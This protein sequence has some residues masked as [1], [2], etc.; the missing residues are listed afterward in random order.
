MPP[1]RK[2]TPEDALS[3]KSVSDAQ[4]SPDGSQVA[5]V[6]GDSF[7]VDTR[8]SRSNIWI[9]DNEVGAT[10]RQ[11]TFEPR[12]DT[13]P[14]WSPDGQS[15]AFLSDR[16]K[17]GQRQVYLL[18]AHGGEGERLTG[19]EG[20]VPS[21]RSLS[22]IAWSPDGRQIAFLMTDPE[23]EEEK[24]R[25]KDKDDAVEF[26]KHG[27]FT[28]INVLDVESR[29]IVYT[30]PA[31]LQVW[32]FCWAP[33]GKEFAVVAS[34]L[35]LEQAWYTC[36]LAAVP[37][38]D[39]PVR[40]LHFSKRQVSKPAWSPDGE[41]VAFL[42][43][44]WSDRGLNAGS[45]FVVSAGGH[46]RNLSEGHD[47]SSFALGWSDDSRKIITFD[48]EQGGMGVGEIDVETGQ[49]MSLHHGEVAFLDSGTTFSRDRSG[50]IAA[51]SEGDGSPPDVGTFIREGNTLKGTHLSRMHPHRDDFKVGDLRSVSW[52]GADGWDMQGLVL[53]PDNAPPAGGAM[54]TIVHGGPT[55]MTAYRYMPACR[56]YGLLA[57]AGFTVF[58][59]NPRG[60]TGWGL[61]FAESNIG[62]MGGK[63]WEDIVKGIDYCVENR[64]ADPDRLGIAGGSYGG[65]MSAWAVTQEPDMF[66]AAVMIAG[67][68]DWRSFHGRSSLCD[69]D[70]IHYGDADPWD[71][72][73]NG[74]YQR[75]SPI[76]YVK[77]AR[78]PTLLL[79][80]EE[81]WDVPV[82][83]S[84]IFYRALK[85]LGVE[86]EL[87]VY[88]REPHGLK[89]R[90][91]ILDSYRRTVDWFSEHLHR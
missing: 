59:P 14:R 44:N 80:G 77:K 27:K 30:S 39:G 54:V 42:T 21:P 24:R 71:P 62:D 74:V 35:P 82:E 18:P 38:G 45:V 84:Y 11:L 83:Q 19:I 79:H 22:P 25:K 52:K 10:A 61:E 41:F 50:A 5:F 75:F 13:A 73:P 2:L 68:S 81:D 4:I 66:K 31:G 86:T 76:T 28:R 87:V 60:S 40:T 23:T 20:K 3:F 67:V 48:H 8:L 91:H 56:Y 32:E 6:V 64:L 43:S 57:T 15:L 1:L 16:D 7:T 47:T 70:A 9:I 51:V 85:D 88:P 63:D 46:V 69:W 12:S 49:R 53:V 89:E 65:F 29:E 90:N 37:M 26:E 58:L 55:G 78:T 33:S 17:D 72:D 36:R 34:D